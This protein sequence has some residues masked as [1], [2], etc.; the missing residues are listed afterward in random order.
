L[1]HITDQFPFILEEVFDHS[2]KKDKLFWPA[3]YESGRLYLEKFN[4]AASGRAFDRA[5]VI[6]ARSAEVLAAKAAAA[7]Q[8]FETK[9]AE[10]FVETALKINPNLTE[11]LRLR[12]DLKL[13][14]GEYE[15]ALKD[16]EKARGV[17]PREEATL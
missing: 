3:E 8:R 12:A 17:N 10:D 16:L 13:F 14:S 4:K 5:L 7:L 15:S 2:V 1:H 11:A 9:E 6:N